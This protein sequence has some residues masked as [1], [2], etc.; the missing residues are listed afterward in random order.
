MTVMDTLW[1]TGVLT[2]KQCADGAYRW[3]T[4]VLRTGREIIEIEPRR[5]GRRLLICAA[6]VRLYRH[7][8]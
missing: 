4:R 1:L 2:N 5:V 3:R 6:S 8:T 7:V